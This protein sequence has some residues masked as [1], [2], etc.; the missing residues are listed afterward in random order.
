MLKCAHKRGALF[1]TEAL[2]SAL[3]VVL[4]LAMLPAES[5]GLQFVYDYYLLSDTYSVLMKNYR[6]QLSVFIST[7]V[8]LGL[9]NVINFVSQ[10]SGRKVFLLSD[11][12]RIGPQCVARS[13]I[14]RIVIAW[15]P[16][17]N[18]AFPKRVTLGVCA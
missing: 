8:D 3:L 1:T 10:Y 6:A 2:L 12:R 16:S 13:T 5:E 18:M 11:G 7:G 4:L 9:S 17:L 15:L 14:E